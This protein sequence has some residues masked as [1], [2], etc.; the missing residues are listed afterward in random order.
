MRQVFAGLLIAALLFPAAALPQQMR[1]SPRRQGL[2][3]VDDR[4]EILA[5]LPV[6]DGSQ[7]CLRWNHSVTGGKVADCFVMTAGRMVL[8]RSYLHDYAAGLGSIPGRG[9]VRAAKG[10]GYWIEDMNEP[11]ADNLLRLRVGS[12]TVDHRL[13][14]DAWQIDLSALATGQRIILRPAAKETM[15]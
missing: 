3:I 2:Q 11:V 5:Q 1:Q 10:G 6:A 14:S 4:G 9:V 13:T 7:F 8:N 15:K 12:P